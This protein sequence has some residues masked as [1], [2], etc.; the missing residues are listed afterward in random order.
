MV[1]SIHPYQ[2]NARDAGA[3]GIQL[4]GHT[5]RRHVNKLREISSQLEELNTV[6]RKFSSLKRQ[7]DAKNDGKSDSYDVSSLHDKLLDFQDYFNE[8]IDEEEKLD[9][10]NEEALKTL[11]SKSGKELDALSRKIDDCLG[12]LKDQASDASNQVYLQGHLHRMIMDIFQE[13]I[14]TDCRGKERLSQASR[15]H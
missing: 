5:D 8:H 3:A 7:I 12:Q 2:I 10:N 13:L 15:G 4:A 14:R 11:K 1:D 9:L 6:L